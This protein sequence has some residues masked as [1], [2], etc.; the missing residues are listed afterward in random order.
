M[1]VQSKYNF[2]KLLFIVVLII[3][4]FLSLLKE[5]VFVTKKSPQVKAQKVL[6]VRNIPVQT[7]SALN[8]SP[9]VTAT[10]STLR[11]DFTVHVPVLMY[12]YIRSGISITENISYGLSITPEV[13]EQQLKYIADNGYQT[14]SL[15]DLSDSLDNHT[16]LPPKSVVLTFDDGYRDFYT[17]A[18]PLLKKYNLRAVSFYV[19]D[20]FNYPGYMTWDMV[21]EIHNS[22]LVAFESH[23]LGHLMLTSL[24]P[25]EARREV[26]ESKKILEEVL[27]KKVTV[28]AY[29][30]GDFNDEIVNLVKEAGYKLAFSTRIGS[31]SHSSERFILKR[32]SVN[33]FDSF[34]VFKAKLNN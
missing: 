32:V 10:T 14:I 34:D 26:F 7:L 2:I 17:T 9:Q 22:G 4:G 15:N 12:H 23:T 24:K 8:F 6:S 25:E 11:S 33:G 1:A 21:K 27:N 5:T 16:P 30:Y 31:D 20:Y 28:F 19:V 3:A 13:L 29:P 18:F